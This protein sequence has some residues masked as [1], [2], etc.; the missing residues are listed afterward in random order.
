[1][2]LAT[3]HVSHEECF[4]LVRRAKERGVERIIITHVDF[5]TTFYTVEE[6]RELASLGAYME[7]CYTTWATK[8]VGLEESIAQIKAIA[9]ERVVISTDLGQAN[10]IYPDE[11]MQAYAEKLIENG[12]SASDVEKMVKD[13]PKGLIL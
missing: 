10:S 1:M 12:F 5:P 13:N 4:A 11:G 6:Q 9:A 3:G 8:K 2:A 7:H